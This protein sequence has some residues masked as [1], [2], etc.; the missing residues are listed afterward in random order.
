MLLDSGQVV[1]RCWKASSCTSHDWQPFS[2]CH[3]KWQLVREMAGKSEG[4]RWC[5]QLP[6]WASAL[7][8][9]AGHP[10]AW[11]QGSTQCAAAG[12]KRARDPQGGQEP[13]ERQCQIF[14][15]NT[16]HLTTIAP[17]SPLGTTS[18]HRTSTFTGLWGLEALS[19]CQS[20]LWLL[21]GE[22][23]GRLEERQQ[24]PFSEPCLEACV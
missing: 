3:G 24:A 22:G 14:S 5:F 10:P 17:S 18:S 2:C 15:C 4:A 8:W 11:A 12:A 19:W 23:A 16:S 1:G 7:F 21:T 20:G 6:H 9:A 13:W